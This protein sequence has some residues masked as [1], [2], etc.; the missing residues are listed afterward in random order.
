MPCIIYLVEQDWKFSAKV[1]VTGYTK[2]KKPQTRVPRAW[3]CNMPP[4]ISVHC[5]MNS[6]HWW[7][8]GVFDGTGASKEYIS[9]PPP[10]F[11]IQ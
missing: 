4:Q 1:S 3:C 5:S 7:L 2:L 9:L 6:K 8:L 11:F 10:L